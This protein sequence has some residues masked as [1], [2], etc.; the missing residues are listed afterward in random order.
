[1]PD[2]NDTLFK[3]KKLEHLDGVITAALAINEGCEIFKGHFPGEPVVPGACMLQIVKD[4][5]ED[6]LNTGLRLKKAGYLKFMAMV[7]PGNT[8]AVD[9]DI[10]YKFDEEGDINVTAKLMSGEVICFKFQGRFGFLL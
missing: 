4:V 1:M 5:L 9:L 10:A 2:K 7:E 3:I 6:T 8:P